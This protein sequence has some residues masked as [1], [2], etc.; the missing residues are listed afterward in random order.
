MS[1]RRTAGQGT[2]RKI[3]LRSG[4][5]AYRGW[6]TV[7][8]KLDA[9]GK[10]KPIKRTCQARTK[11]EV[12]AGLE[13]LRAKYR[14]GIALDTERIRMRELFDKW[15]AHIELI[16]DPPARTLTA[17]RWAANRICTALDNPL[18][19][20]VGPFQLQTMLTALGEQL[21]RDSLNTIRAVLRLAF[22]QAKV[23]RIIADN[24]AAEL[25]L[26]KAPK[27][28]QH[29]RALT[30]EEFARFRDALRGERLELA[31]LITAA[32]GTR[33]GETAAIRLSQIDLEA[34]TLTIDAQ[35]QR[36]RETGKIERDATKGDDVRIFRV[37]EWL[38]LAIAR[39]IERLASERRA[40]GDAWT[41]PD[42]GLLFVRETDGGPIDGE[43][44]YAV[45]RRAAR[46]AGLGKVVTHDL[47][48]TLQSQLG[49]AGVDR[50]VRAS[51]A[52]HTDAD[53][54]DKHYR[55]VYDGE[56]AE[57]LAK[58]AQIL[59]L[60]QPAPEGGDDAN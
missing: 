17:Y 42:Q 37:D 35:H 48:R 3:T 47:R 27:Q 31:V 23:W 43:Q 11:R 52:G 57:A 36:N 60:D 15:L 25:E 13:R 7:D 49:K 45:V 1:K 22:R 41:E 12:E 2:I 44:I 50:N 33:R 59:G 39:H 38:R 34:G 9:T 32:F 5:T 16:D 21:K 46:R 54:T 53:T 28:G 18:V 26:P 40:M 56:A 58:M 14:I 4:A 29:G 24:P 8:Y 20:K 10:P 51:I 6:L 55:Y 30:A 19:V